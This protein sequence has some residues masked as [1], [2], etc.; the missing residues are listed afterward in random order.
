MSPA[1]SF[2]ATLTLAALLLAAAPASAQLNGENLLGDTGVKNGSQPMP[3]FYAG[4]LYFRSYT[5]T[6]KN[7][8]GQRIV[9]APSE[10]ANQTMNVVAPMFIYVS[11]ATLFGG[12]Y[13]MMAVA[14]LANG[15][16][17][18]PA[19]GLE[20]SVSTNISDMYVVPFQ[21]GWHLSRADVTTA[22]G[23]FAP[24]GSYT[25]GGE[26]LGKGM[27]SYELSA[28]T[29]MYL[30][31]RRT[32]SLATTAYWETHTKKDGTDE[33]TFE[34]VTLAGVRVGQLL[35]LEG[36]AAK[37]FLN[38]AA[39]VGLAYYAQWKITDDDFGTPATVPAPPVGRH[40]V[41]GIGPDATTP[42]ASKWALI[43]LVN[44]RYMWEAGAQA[45]TQGQSL[46]VTAT[47]PIP[48]F[49][50]PAKH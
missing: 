17:Q 20:E 32:L 6:I 19:F 27:W 35:T 4:T 9:F 23:F 10:P 31:Q 2:V 11:K 24:T 38:G 39:H 50:I 22:F 48:S 18:A 14:P 13:G 47:F 28:G 16:L 45:K 36:G 21:L 46:V 44:V 26:N 41:F 5:D 37:S 30:D 7:K 15:A 1:R 3:G 49:K 40:R 43:S 34:D 33:L 42:I 25:P 29:T 12:H 8:N